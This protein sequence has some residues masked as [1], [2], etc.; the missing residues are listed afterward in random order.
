MKKLVISVIALVTWLSAVFGMYQPSM[1]ESKKVD[2][3]WNV[4]LQI[5]ET[6]H[7][8][9]YE[10][11]L[12]LLKGFQSRVTWDERK[13]WILDTLISL[14]M[15]KIWMN[16]KMDKKMMD[17]KM[18]DD[19]MMD[20]KMMDKK[21]MD[22][23][24]MDDKMMDDKM[25]KNSTEL[26]NV[27]NGATI[28]WIVY[29]GSETWRASIEFDGTT[30]H[31]YAEFDNIPHPGADNFYEGWIVRQNGGFNFF[32]T[33][34]LMEKDGKWVNTRSMEWDLTDHIQYVLTLEPNDND[35]A[36]ADHIIEGDV[37]IS[38]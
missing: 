29:N 14:T 10:L 27:T 21:M 16:N 32:S 12:G 34:E 26:A 19:K 36:P 5:I 4:L 28:R 8:G 37:V 1:K 3:A 13:E 20:D 38:M 24:M 17:D 25:M 30:T 11:L 23:K 22:D 15:D 35:P 7:D 33:W 2:A 31:V 9:N 18:M 6:K